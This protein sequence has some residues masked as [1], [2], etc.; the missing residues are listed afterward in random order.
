MT[1]VKLA[2]D[3][4][5]PVKLTIGK[6]PPVILLSGGVR[7]TASTVTI[8]GKPR[9]PKL[10]NAGQLQVKLDPEDSKETGE[11]TLVVSNPE[12]NASTAKIVIRVAPAITESTPAQLDVDQAVELKVEGAG[13]HADCKAKIGGQ[14]RATKIESP[15]KLTVTPV[16]A[17]VKAAGDLQLVAEILRP[18][19]A[20]PC[21]RHQGREAGR[22]RS[23][24]S[25]GAFRG[26]D[27]Y[28]DR[29]AD[30]GGRRKRP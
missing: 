21:I 8:N 27:D 25:T 26:T 6:A 13:F 18:T 7:R 30:L 11:L 17:D 4:A 15:T 1:V 5:D 28:R 3:N 2:I 22:R 29:P 19:V 12:P 9:E 16:A 24:R 10:I 23:C 14:V 20:H